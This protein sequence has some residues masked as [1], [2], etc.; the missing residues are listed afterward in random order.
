MSNCDFVTARLLIDLAASRLAL[1]VPALRSVTTLTR[2]NRS[3][4]WLACDRHPC[5]ARQRER[6]KRRVTS[7]SVKHRDHLS[8][9]RHGG[10]FR[11]FPSDVRRRWKAL[12]TSFQ[13][14]AL[15]E[16]M[17]PGLSIKTLEL[18]KEMINAVIERRDFAHPLRM[19][20]TARSREP[21]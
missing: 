3:A 1:R 21:A 2:P 6:P 10:D 11:E 12:S 15:R 7:Y 8:H 16:A 19:R 4:Q 18:L 9:H 5:A 20:D 13:L 14:P 17:T